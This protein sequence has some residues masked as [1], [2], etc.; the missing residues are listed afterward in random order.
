MVETAGSS[1]TEVK[2][3]ILTES[4][5]KKSST[6]PKP[7]TGDDFKPV[8][9]VLSRVIGSKNVYEVNEESY[10]VMMSRHRAQR[11]VGN[12]K[13]DPTSEREVLGESRFLDEIG[14]RV[15]LCALNKRITPAKVETPKK[16]KVWPL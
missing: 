3:E 5:A 16:T 4:G 13:F 2:T 9:D 6:D 15:R 12:C 11:R 14:Q 10:K 1:K 8:I 7:T